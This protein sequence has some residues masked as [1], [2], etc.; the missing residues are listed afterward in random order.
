[1]T[2]A[3][4]LSK[5]RAL[6]EVGNRADSDHPDYSALGGTT[7]RA[8]KSI[9]YAFPTSENAKTLGFSKTGCWYISV[10]HTDIEGSGQSRTFL[11][12]DAEG[13]AKADDPDLISLYLETEGLMDPSFKEY[14]SLEALHTIFQR[15]RRPV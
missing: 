1:M 15:S 6:Y 4:F 8:Y 14:G 10:I 7:M 12:H 5:V 3:Q 9:A 13:F 2:K 11:P